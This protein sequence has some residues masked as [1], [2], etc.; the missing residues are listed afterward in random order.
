M[1][2]RGMVPVLNPDGTV[3]YS[4][5]YPAHKAA[6]IGPQLPGSA[7]RAGVRPDLAAAGWEVSTADGPGGMTNVYRPG[8][9]QRDQ[10]ENV[11]KRR[12]A[13]RAG[14]PSAQAQGM[15][16]D[17]LRLASQGAA[18][19]EAIDRKKAW[20]AQ[21]MLAGGQPTGGR[22]GSKA[23][24]N[25]LMTMPEDE[26]NSSLRYMMPGGQLAA[27]VD[28]NA[29]QQAFELAKQ[30]ALGAGFQ[31]PNSPT[32]KAAAQALEAKR[33]KEN[34]EAA[35]VS[36]LSS[37]NP[38]S[39]EAQAEAD[40]LAKSM[41]ND[42]GGFSYESEIALAQRLQQPPYNMRQPEAEAAAHRAAENRR[43][44]WNQGGSPQKPATPGNDPA[45]WGAAPPAGPT[46]A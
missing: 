3:G 12:L 36:D 32:A 22:A 20:K 45:A 14:I 13:R 11:D 7:G 18:D 46:G 30:M 35:G 8:Q 34:P 17:Q 9:N 4:V 41:D 5:G 29:N 39:T 15:T 19:D 27:T 33:R 1:A 28:A 40:R 2:A 26:R 43:W 10:I 44:W 23:V 25:A 38:T 6:D 37:G 21:T 16:I 31:D 24:T 42:L